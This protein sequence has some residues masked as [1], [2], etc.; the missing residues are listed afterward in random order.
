VIDF[1][2]AKALHQRLTDQTVYTQFAQMV[3]TPLYMSPEQAGMGVID[4]DTRSDVY[5]LGVVLYELLTGETPFDRERLKSATFDEMRRIIREEEPQRP[6]AMV[7]TLKAE[8]Q[9]TIAE[10][11]GIDVRKLSD[12]LA[13]ELDWLVMRAL[14]KDRGRRYESANSLADDIERYLG[15]QPVMAC[16]PSRIYALQKFA[17][18]NR[19]L[20]TV[21]SLVCALLLVGAGLLWNE[22]RRTLAALAES[23]ANFAK[24]SQQKEIAEANLQTAIEAVDQMLAQVGSE[25]L[26]NVPQ[27]TALRLELLRDASDSTPC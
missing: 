18:R 7:S 15:D 19:A 2:V 27:M 9:S 14:E 4:V 8:A 12:S 3:G 13:G 22:R 21:V 6:S 26:D 17:T 10:R 25:R 5:S 16:P 1:G 24:A 23:D 20:V 11:R